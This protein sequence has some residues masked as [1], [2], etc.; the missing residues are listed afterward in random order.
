MKKLVQLADK[1]FGTMEGRVQEHESVQV[2]T[3][4]RS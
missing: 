4:I 2:G 1:T 3:G